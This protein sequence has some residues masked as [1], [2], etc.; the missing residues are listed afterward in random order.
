MSVRFPG[1]PIELAG[2][3]PNGHFTV[4]YWSRRSLGAEARLGTQ[5]TSATAVQTNLH[6]HIGL[7]GLD[8]AIG[9]S[10]IG[11]GVI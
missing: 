7:L 1:L 10:A 5:V 11:R 2:F 9:T 4:G 8:E 3:Y 6:A